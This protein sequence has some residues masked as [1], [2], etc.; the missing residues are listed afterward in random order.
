[1]E[2]AMY[3]RL[4]WLTITSN[5]SLFQTQKRT[6]GLYKIREIPLLAEKIIAS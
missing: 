4:I 3:S 2:V 6:F 5:P 1:M